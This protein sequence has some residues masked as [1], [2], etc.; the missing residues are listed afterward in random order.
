ME[1]QRQC[2]TLLKTHAGDVHGLMYSRKAH[3]IIWTKSPYRSAVECDSLSATVCVQSDCLRSA[4]L[5]VCL[6]LCD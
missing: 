3:L 1:L 5:S 4:S 2:S 6:H